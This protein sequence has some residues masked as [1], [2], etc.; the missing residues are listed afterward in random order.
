MTIASVL[1][2]IIGSCYFIWA[3]AIADFSTTSIMRSFAVLMIGLVLVLFRLHLLY[4][5]KAHPS[6]SIL[7]LIMIG[8]IAFSLSNKAFIFHNWHFVFG[9]LIIYLSTISVFAVPKRRIITKLSKGFVALSGC[10]LAFLCFFQ[11]DTALIFEISGTLLLIATI[12]I[13]AGFF[14]K[15]KST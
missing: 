5:H 12:L 15:Q 1:A 4:R 7:A 6:V 2:F 10:F 8:L 3:A 11:I 13:V 14:L 9:V